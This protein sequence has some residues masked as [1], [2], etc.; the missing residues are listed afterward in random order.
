MKSL[1]KYIKMLK[2][3]LQIKTMTILSLV[4]FAL[5]IVY[6]LID[7]NSNGMIP[8]SGLYMGIAGTYIYSVAITPTV[9]SLVQ[10]SGLNR[11]LQTYVPVLFAGVS[12]AFTFT[13]FAGLRLFVGRARL[14]AADPAADTTVI[15]VNILCTAVLLAFLCLYYSFSYRYYVAATIVLCVILFPLLFLFIRMDWG[16]SQQIC[17]Y[18]AGIIEKHGTVFVCVLSYAVLALGYI[19]GYLANCALFR[20]PMSTLAFRAA[21]RQAESK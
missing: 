13:V 19:L 14:L 6:E 15:Y 3:G 21:L 11:K 8:F 5:G 10:T 16:I 9:S 20:K 2:F 18:V 12:G 17:A 4:F 7:F 1:S